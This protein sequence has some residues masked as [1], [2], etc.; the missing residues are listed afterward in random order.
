LEIV[1]N[2]LPS[3][4]FASLFLTAVWYKIRYTH[5]VRKKLLA[6]TD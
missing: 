5:Q 1:L 6:L 4:R 2:A 3:K